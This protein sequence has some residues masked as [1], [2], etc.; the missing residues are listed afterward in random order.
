MRSFMMA[1][2]EAN[3]GSMHRVC[4]FPSA[5]FARARANESKKKRNISATHTTDENLSKLI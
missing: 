3:N 4:K 5:S 1:C 2:F